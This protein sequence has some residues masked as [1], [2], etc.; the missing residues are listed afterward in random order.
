MAAAILRFEDS[1]VT[2]PDSLRVS[3]L[4]AADKAAE[5]AEAA[6][7]RKQ[8]AAAAT[9]ERLEANNR[10]AAAKMCIRDRYITYSFINLV[11]VTFMGTNGHKWA[12]NRGVWAHFA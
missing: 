5:K 9:V 11:M 1:L 4:P 7:A 3:R 6:E 10:R 8:Q 12:Q 2:G